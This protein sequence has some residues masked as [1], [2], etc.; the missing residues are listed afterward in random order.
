MQA[1]VFVSASNFDRTVFMINPKG[2]PHINLNSQNDQN[3]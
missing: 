3:N 1:L 2:D